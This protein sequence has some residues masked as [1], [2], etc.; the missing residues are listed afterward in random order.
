MPVIVPTL[1]FDGQCE[2]AL[3]LYKKAFIILVFYFR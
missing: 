2:E 1:N 3:R